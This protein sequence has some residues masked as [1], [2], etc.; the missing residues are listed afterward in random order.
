MLPLSDEAVVFFSS[1]QILSLLLEPRRGLA[2]F[3][4]ISCA[5]STLSKETFLS[6]FPPPLALSASV[7]ILYRAAKETREFETF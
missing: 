5:P 2:G 7:H 1:K 6:H 3:T 4:Q